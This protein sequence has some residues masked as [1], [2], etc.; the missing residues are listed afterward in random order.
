M[1]CFNLAVVVPGLS[2]FGQ[3]PRYAHI[4]YTSS[5]ASLGLKS[6]TVDCVPR[7]LFFLSRKVYF[8]H[9]PHRGWWHSFPGAS[10]FGR[11]HESWF[12]Q[13]PTFSRRF[14][15]MVLYLQAVLVFIALHPRSKDSLTRQ[16]LSLADSPS[17]SLGKGI[18]SDWT[19]NAERRKSSHA[20][21]RVIANSTDSVKQN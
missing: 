2:T 20:P 16:V 21:Y 18:S 17:N 1:Y 7:N 10:V 6:M 5:I 15:L 12:L 14:T 11:P 13:F 4:M 3:R 9:G 8:L 19:Q